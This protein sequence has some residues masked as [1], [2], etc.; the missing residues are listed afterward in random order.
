MHAKSSFAHRLQAAK[1]ASFRTSAQNNSPR[2]QNNG[3]WVSSFTA[4]PSD[5]NGYYVNIVLTGVE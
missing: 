5:A 4:P 1:M 3:P 2:A